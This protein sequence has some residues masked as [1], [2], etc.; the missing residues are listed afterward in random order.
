MPWKN[1]VKSYPAPEVIN[2]GGYRCIQV[3]VPDDPLYISEFFQA[4]RFFGTWLAWPR[5]NSHTGKQIADIWKDGIN[6][7]V[8]AW[9]GQE[10][11]LPGPEGPEGP[12]GPQGPA[13]S[14]GS[15]GPQGP[16]G[17]PAG[18]IY[19][20]D[21]GEIPFPEGSDKACETATSAIAYMQ[22][23]VSEIANQLD[24]GAA[25]LV[26]V[27]VA[28]GILS[29]V[30]TIGLDIVIVVA[31]ISAIMGIS[32]PTFRGW[33][34]ETLWGTLKEYLY[35]AAQPDGIITAGGWDCLQAQWAEDTGPGWDFIK[36]LLSILKQG[37]TNNSNYLQVLGSA[38]CTGLSNQ[39]CPEYFEHVFDFAGGLQG[40]T[41]DAFDDGAFRPVFYGWGW[42]INGSIVF[43]EARITYVEYSGYASEGSGYNKSIQGGIDPTTSNIAIYNSSGPGVIGVIGDNLDVQ[44]S[45]LGFHA[46]CGNGCGANFYIDRFIVHGYR[47]GGDPFE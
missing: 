44:C 33:F 16:A 43:Q 47:V 38:D 28:I 46:D 32:G 18:P 22:H 41:S 2:P 10:G 29:L 26:M 40:W 39:G 20:E 3:L 17:T 11:C 36:G 23:F 31:F 12:Q 1:P 27:A 9:E 21:P 35:S 25:L 42:A 45:K 14:T 7:A 5:D 24:V 6:R 13:G 4:Y 37:A 19:P 30:V 8:D 34:D 15:T